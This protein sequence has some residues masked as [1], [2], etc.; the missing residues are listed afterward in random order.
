M[1]ILGLPVATFGSMMIPVCLILYSIY[2]CITKSYEGKKEE[3]KYGV[4]EDW[5]YTF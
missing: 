1:T 3:E 2:A 4:E 5:Y